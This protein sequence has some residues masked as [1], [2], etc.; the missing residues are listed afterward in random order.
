MSY[1]AE[2]NRVY[3][4]MKVFRFPMQPERGVNESREGENEIT[5]KNERKRNRV[6]EDKKKT[7]ERETECERSGGFDYG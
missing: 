7:R 3:A 2:K 5:K 4:R 6:T 1:S